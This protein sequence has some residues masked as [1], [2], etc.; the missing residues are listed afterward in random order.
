[1]TYKIQGILMNLKTGMISTPQ[2]PGIRNF[3]WKAGLLLALLGVSSQ[4]GAQTVRWEDYRGL[5]GLSTTAYIGDPSKPAFRN[6]NNQNPIANLRVI[7]S[8]PNNAVRTGTSTNIDFINTSNPLCNVNLSGTSEACRYQAMGKVIYALVQFPQAGAY[9][10]SVAHD[11][12]V[13]V[14][15]SSDYANTNYRS[16]SYD[17]PVGAV[18]EWTNSE[19]DYSD[20]GTF[21]A[22][23][24]NSCA[25]IRVYWS[26]QN[27]VTFNRL[28]WRL[29]NSTV[30]V[31]PAENFRDP[32]SAASAQG[33]QGSITGNGA[34]ITLNKIVGSQRIDASDQFT[35]G[36]ASSANGT[37]IRQD[38]TNGAG[39]GQQAS[40]GALL[41]TTGTTYYLRDAMA[42]G[43]ASVLGSYIST[44]SCTR[45]D[46]P[47]NPGGASPVWTVVPAAN[48]K[49]VCSITN[50][51][52]PRLRIHKVSL[53]GTGSFN[54]TG[55]N[56]IPAQT[57]ATTTANVAVAGVASVL[58]AA[59]VAT[60]VT[61]A[62][63]PGK[64]VL[65]SISCTGLGSGGTAA[66][67]L[68]SRSVTLDA[69][70]TALGSA[71]DC[72]FTN[73]RKMANLSITKSN[74]VSQVIRG[75]PFDYS[76][77][78]SNAGPDATEAR[79]QDADMSANLSC[80]SVQC[81]STSGGAQCPDGLTPGGLQTGTVL[82]AMPPGGSLTFT[83]TCVAN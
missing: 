55:S 68:A 27:G 18:S 51:A 5:S 56:G 61:E 76:I 31:V 1:M 25:L 26:N 53:G 83:L 59:G 16:A 35:V 49:I 71:I 7:S 82:P 80:S 33:C 19:N 44:I 28:R 43:S 24:A 77:V 21:T 36:I 54:F 10:M 48:D 14:N 47:F 65:E 32:S 23:N 67:N 79:L 66:V 38:S 78:V 9:T 74:G 15:L 57:L 30:Q 8:D 34:A 63:P 12:N 13:E 69:A 20:L 72:T 37:A 81:A 75:K 60:S 22:A 70:A 3:K 4:A 52:R 11:D 39:T 6:L 29:P 58:T 73:R 40:T 42:S 2:T 41:A 64:F 45:N 62:T 46:V 50:T 17:I